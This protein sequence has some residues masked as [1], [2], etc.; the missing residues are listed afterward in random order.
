MWQIYAL[1]G[2]FTNA[3]E[4]SIDKLAIV[5]GDMLDSTIA[6]FHRVAIYTIIIII[7]GFLSWGGRIEL[8]LDWRI[9][10]F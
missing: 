8:S 5:S 4:N 10:S 1:L 2:L 7:V 9:I 6:T 3:V